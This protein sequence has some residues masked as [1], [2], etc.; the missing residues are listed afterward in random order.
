M[1]Y[2]EDSHAG[3]IQK[4]NASKEIAQQRDVRLIISHV[5]AIRQARSGVTPIKE[6]H[7]M[8]DNEKTVNKVKGLMLT[9]NAQRELILM[10]RALVKSKSI[11]HWKKDYKTDE[12]RIEHD[13]H[14]HEND[15]NKLILILNKL[16]A[17]EMDILEAEK[18]KNVDDDFMI[19]KHTSEGEVCEVTQNHREMLKELEDS[20]EELEFIMYRNGVISS[21][22]EVDEEKTAK[23]LEEEMINRIIE[24]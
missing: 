19:V 18:T 4:F 14:S 15:Y 16:E 17:C 6:V 5:N 9:I 8:S 7:E 12:E 3:E 21:G 13:F 20:Y 1:G 11:N 24:A 10:S 22:M 23:E 2:E